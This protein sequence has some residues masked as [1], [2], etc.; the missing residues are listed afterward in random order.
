M[1]RAQGCCSAR[2]ARPANLRKR[3]LKRIR[4]CLTC[5]EYSKTENELYKESVFVGYRYTASA[6]AKPRYPFGFGLS[7][8]E[9]S[10]SD[11]EV[12]SVKTAKFFASVTVT[13]VGACRGAKLCRYMLQTRRIPP[14]SARKKE[15]RAFEKVWL[16]P[17]ESR[18]VT[19]SFDEKDLSFLMC[20]KTVLCLKTENTRFR[21]RLLPK[22]PFFAKKLTVSSG[23]KSLARIPPRSMRR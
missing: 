23:E 14:C 22:I 21:Y 12:F 5:A 2:P 11:P 15:L 10:Y 13:N 16:D 6:D 19:L 1:R 7:Y 3:G 18:C 9:F 17:S 20:P 4:S 8:T